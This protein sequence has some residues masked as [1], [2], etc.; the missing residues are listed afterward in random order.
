M[1]VTKPADV[2]VAALSFSIGPDRYDRV[3]SGCHKSG[4]DTGQDPGNQAYRN[5]QHYN[6]KWNEDLEM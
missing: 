4:N 6:I 5:G 3:H 1:P 2:D